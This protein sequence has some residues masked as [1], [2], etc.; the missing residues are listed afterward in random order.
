MSTSDL[1]DKVAIVT[2]SGRNIGKAA[3][4]EL[5]R[6]G[7]AVIVNGSR[8][9]DAVEATVA[10]IKAAGGQALGVMADVARDEDCKRLVDTAVEAFGGADILVSN[11]GVRRYRAFLDMSPEEW[12]ETLGTNLTPAFLLSRHAIPH[13]Q[14]RRWGRIILVSGFDGFWGNVSHRAA[15]V[16]AKAGLHGLAKALAR[17]F[18]ADGITANTVAPGAIDTERDWS[19]YPHQEKQRVESEIPAGRFGNTA[20]VAA[21]IAFLASPG[22]GFCSGQ[23]THVN[24]G[25]FMF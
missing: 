24:G 12:N 15:N 5:A 6:H 16:T 10:D 17:E 19:Q 21:A 4:I 11:V 25:H 18:G 9:R 23:A 13:M 1:R 14:K 3:A 20:E 8:D 2:G 7:A 22:A